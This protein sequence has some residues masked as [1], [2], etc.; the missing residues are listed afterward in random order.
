MSASR[1]NMVGTSWFAAC[2]FCVLEE[3]VNQHRHAN[4]HCAARNARL[5]LPLIRG[6]PHP[7]L[8]AIVP[9]NNLPDLDASGYRCHQDLGLCL[10]LRIFL[11]ELHYHSDKQQQQQ[12]QEYAFHFFLQA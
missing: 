9:S 4:V 3:E 11:N 10:W 1:T 5:V 7:I 6:V 12:Q 2:F 8:V